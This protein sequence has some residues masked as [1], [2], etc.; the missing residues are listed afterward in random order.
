MENDQKIFVEGCERMNWKRVVLISL[1][2]FMIVGVFVA[3]YYFA[4]NT[5]I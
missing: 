2:I 5:A 4:D 1:G 3:F